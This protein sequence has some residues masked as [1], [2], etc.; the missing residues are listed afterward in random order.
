MDNLRF[1]VATHG[2]SRRGFFT[3]HKL[4]EILISLNYCKIHFQFSPKKTLL[5]EDTLY[6]IASYLSFLR[7]TSTAK[8]LCAEE[9]LSIYG[10]MTFN[11]NGQRLI[12]LA[13][14]DKT[15]ERK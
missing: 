15:V 12:M 11:C 8:V 3:P 14:Q 2:I 13:I 5:F 9:K 1:L 6:T 7:D 4:L 10:N